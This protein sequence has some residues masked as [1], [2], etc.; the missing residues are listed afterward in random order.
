MAK[1]EGEWLSA[2]AERLGV[3]LPSDEERETLLALAGVAAH[4]S[5]RTAAPLS[6][7]M[8]G[9]SGL[10]PSTAMQLVDELGSQA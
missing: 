9:K 1:T 4:A 7:W 2:L 10:D 3:E 6:C 5:E 8:V